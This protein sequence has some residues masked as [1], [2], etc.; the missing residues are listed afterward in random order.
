MGFSKPAPSAGRHVRPLSNEDPAPA[1]R[2]SQLFPTTLPRPSW[3][4]DTLSPVR[5]GIFTP[6]CIAKAVF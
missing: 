5:E 6:R 4:P 3:S 2:L 1:E